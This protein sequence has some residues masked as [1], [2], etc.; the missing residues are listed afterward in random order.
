MGIEPGGIGFN[1]KRHF[2]FGFYLVHP[3]G[4]GQIAFHINEFAGLYP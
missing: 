4:G 2:L 3:K 1:I